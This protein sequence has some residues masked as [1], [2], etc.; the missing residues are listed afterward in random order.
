MTVRTEL[1][2]IINGTGKTNQ[3]LFTFT[4]NVFLIRRFSFLMVL[5]WVGKDI[6]LIRKHTPLAHGGGKNTWCI[7]V[8][9]HEYAYCTYT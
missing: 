7:Y 6:F 9:V 4:P 2:G 5:I 1:E 3:G 8:C